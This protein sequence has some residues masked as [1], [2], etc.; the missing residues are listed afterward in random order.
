MTISFAPS[1]LY[2]D[3]VRLMHNPLKTSFTPLK[4]KISKFKLD[5]KFNTYIEKLFR[6]LPNCCVFVLMP[7]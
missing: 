3:L 5:Y 7:L 4:V 6:P 1:K 2:I